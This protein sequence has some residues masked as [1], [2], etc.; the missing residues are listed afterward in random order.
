[1]SGVWQHTSLLPAPERRRQA[2]LCELESS[3]HME[4]QHIDPVLEKESDGGGRKEKTKVCFLS[5]EQGP[6]FSHSIQ[7]FH[8]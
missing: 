5:L 7:T 6:C 1:M 4:T 8:L 3:L 2:H